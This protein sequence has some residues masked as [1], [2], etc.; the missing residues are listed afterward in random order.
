MFLLL[1][2]VLPSPIGGT[3]SHSPMSVLGGAKLLDETRIDFLALK[4]IG[5]RFRHDT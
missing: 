2:L 3:I 4:V 5:V 1:R